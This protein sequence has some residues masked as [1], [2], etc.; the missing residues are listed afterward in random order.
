MFK[1]LI[2]DDE[3]KTT[4]VPLVRDE[5]TIGRKEGNTIR[6]TER[7]ISRDHARLV[8]KAAS[9]GGGDPYVLEAKE[10]Y[11]GVHVNGLRV[12]EPT[13]LQHGDLIQLGDYRIVYQD[14]SMTEATAPYVPVTEVEGVW[15]FRTIRKDGREWGTAMSSRVDGPA[16]CE[17]GDGG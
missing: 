17:W 14:E 2:A 1:L 9:P 3:G 8:R 12:A 13:E 5:V 15:Q 6:L 7:N 16:A 10:S 4:V 11:N